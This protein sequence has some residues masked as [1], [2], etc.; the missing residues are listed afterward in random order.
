MQL[1]IVLHLHGWCH[2]FHSEHINIRRYAALAYVK[3]PLDEVLARGHDAHVRLDAREDDGVAALLRLQGVQPRRDLGHQH[4][5]VRLRGHLRAR[6]VLG[7]AEVG[8]Q[9]G[10]RVAEALVSH[11]EK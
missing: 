10:H 8:A 6:A 7:D 5:E 9:G 3:S 4:R 1:K 2:K 11:K